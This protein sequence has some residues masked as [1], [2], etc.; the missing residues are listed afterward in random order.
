ML[1]GNL[2]CLLQIELF[3]EENRYICP[4]TRFLPLSYKIVFFYSGP[5][6]PISVE[7][8]G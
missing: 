4:Y 1:R 8:R 5:L 2:V 6:D 7:M 3:F